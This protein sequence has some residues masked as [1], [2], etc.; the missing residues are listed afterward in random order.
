MKR[1]LLRV[2][3]GIVSA[4]LILFAFFAV[5]LLIS[6]MIPDETVWYYV[7][8]IQRLLTGL[9]AA[10]IF[11]LLYGKDRLKETFSMKGFGKGLSASAMLLMFSA[12]CIA[13][14]FIGLKEFSVDNAWD[15]TGD[16]VFTTIM[17]AFF[18]EMV[19]RGLMIEGYFLIKHQNRLTRLIFVFLSSA[20]FAACHTQ[21]YTEPLKLFQLFALGFSLA[22]VYIFS[23]NM[24]LCTSLHCMYNFAVCLLKYGKNE[25]GT[26]RL[27]LYLSLDFIYLGMFIVGLIFILMKKPYATSQSETTEKAH[28]VG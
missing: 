28:P 3:F 27:S 19:L 21:Y 7:S 22:S 13:L 17:T 9:A 1:P 16:V 11:A 2:F 18:E 20:V 12:V 10:A 24:L 5:S 23:K 26:L 15:F 14:L 25:N 4:I 8:G 6:L